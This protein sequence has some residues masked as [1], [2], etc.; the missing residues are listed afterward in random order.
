M[1]L[2]SSPDSTSSPAI[3]R[4]T[5]LRLHLR[6]LLVCAAVTLSLAISAKSAS[7]QA[8]Y[9][10]IL[11]T[12]TDSTGAVVP[13]ATI[14]VTDV[15]KGTSVKVQTNGSGQYSVQHLIS[16]IYSVAAE[17]SGFAKTTQDG[18]QVYVDT[19]P[20]VDLVL[21]TGATAQTVT[22]TGGAPL[23][24][25]DRSDVS[26]V[27]NA[28]A[29]EQLPNVNRNFTAFELLT[30][31]TTYI[32]WNVGQAQNPQQSQQIEVNGQLPFATGYE[33]DGTDN[34]DP[35]IGVAVIN[36][37][38][39]AISE[40]KVT[41]QN[42]NAEQGKAVAGLVT[43]QTKSGSNAFHGS[44]F[45]YRRSDAQQARDPFTQSAPDP[46]TGRYIPHFLHNQFGGSIGG[47]IFKDKAFF[48][49]D[50]QGLRE[51]TGVSVL[52]TVPTALARTSCL[53]TTTC[54]L[55]EYL[56]GGQ[57][58]V[59]NP[60]SNPTGTAGRTAF[61]GNL[62]PTNMLSTPA[63]NLLK[64]LPAPNTGA[65][66]L[67]VNN[68]VASGS[69]GF[70]TNQVDGR[71]DFQVSS[72]LHVFGRYT[73]FNSNLNGTPYF[74][75][76]GGNGFGSGNF[77]GSDNA[78]DQSVAAGGDYVL[79]AK[80]LTDFRFG[81]FRIYLNE[82]GPDFNQPVGTALGIPGVN[83][84]DLSLYGGLPQFNIDGFSNNSTVYGSTANPFLQT[85]NQFQ[86]VNNWTHTIGNHTIRFGGDARYALNH[87]VGLDN[88][89]LRSGNFHF[90]ASA[91]QGPPSNS[92]G[93]G[94]ATF[95]LGD[96]TAFQRTQ[97]Q[98]NN[99]Q[100]R[101][102]R[103]FSFA[104]DEWRVTNKLTVNYG[105]RWEIYFPETVNGKG[106]GGLLDLGTGNIR[107]AGYGPYGTNLNV[108]NELTHISPRI[109]IAYQASPGT[110]VRAGFGRVYG[111]GWSGDTFGEVL[112]FTYPAQISQNLNAATNN[113][114]LFNLSQG[115]PGY[116]FAPIPASGNY[117]LPDGVS[118]PTRP[119][120]TRIPT[121]DGW[122]L[123]VEQQ[124]SSTSS[125]RFQYV[126]S[127]G[128]HN[129]FDSSNQASPN[130]PTLN[131]YK[132]SN[133][134]GV[135]YTQND[136]RPYYD[137]V[138]QTLG[139]NYGAPYGWTQ[140]LRYNANEATTS[141]QALQVVY[142][143]RFSKGYQV[144]T[145]YT[146]SKA[147]AHES[148]Y[149][150]IDPRADYGNSYYNRP[151]AFVLTG[152]WDLPIGR[153]KSL[154]SNMPRFLNE[155]VGGFALNGALTY[156]SGLPFT[157]SYSACTQDQDIDGQGGSLCRPNR[158]GIGYGL[159]AGAFDPINHNVKYFNGIP[160]L[161]TNGASFGPYSRPQIRQFGNIE[162]DSL[163][164][165]HLANTDFSVAKNFSLTERLRFQ[166]TVQ[167]FN[168]FNHANLATP[169]SCVD[170]QNANAGLVT[171]VISSQDGSSMRRL[172]FAGRFQF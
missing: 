22:V 23:L 59:Y 132:L 106:Q 36:P 90:A 154:G 14:T 75:G 21:S 61:A 57:G 137:G 138:A 72:K 127:H 110:V 53:T 80:W 100:E 48:F 63:L 20:K 153:G 83:Q 35:I 9:G 66:N 50:Y 119:L 54:N 109:G 38:L 78:K 131:G 37:N 161:A 99:A 146:W 33:L 124:V 65:S 149:F 45:E 118:V 29:V 117:P 111:Q 121:L 17:A 96:V 1:Q 89:N 105:V 15:A 47:P 155:I 31:G 91:T 148:D 40:E 8:V 133:A 30:P 51:K 139:V 41:S 170:C 93:L 94:L 81:W 6:A 107:V 12:V 77:A 102:K 159:G 169:N 3:L 64:A 4:P 39:D 52:Q 122:N 101:Q 87:L 73:F 140:D 32:G 67:I 70:N 150:F 55:S 2:H 125:I 42:Y 5:S 24:E 86:I 71:V 13:N 56:Q 147:R 68:Y 62:I 116:T 115:P 164:G 43:A 79:S 128:I 69:G 135:A 60:A 157:P 166:A 74:G 34:Q 88:N 16:D 143:K 26:T 151:Q 108:N 44:A 144:L 162:R 123:A 104:Q 25:T 145:H 97:I 129:M 85:E 136:R 113:A 103:I 58:Q 120:T 126:G 142:E 84:G 28:R 82:Q 171:D 158:T 114:S 10:S 95:L 112:T 156:Q 11:G 165:P 167:A 141:Y 98:A 168:V 19:A 152:N 76:A 172:Q 92:S 130:Q 134:N 18:V 163:Y 27:L 49:G 46:N 160:A 7:A